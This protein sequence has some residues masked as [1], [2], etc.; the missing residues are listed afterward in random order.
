MIH[1]VSG[2]SPAAVWDLLRRGRPVVVTDEVGRWP[3]ARRWTFEFMREQHGSIVV[4]AEVGP[5]GVERETFAMRLGDYVDRLLDPAET[6]L[7]LRHWEF[8]RD[9]P[10]LDADQRLPS[11]LQDRPRLP[12]R[13][14]PR[15]NWI[16]M[17]PRGSRTHLHVDALGTHSWLAQLRGRKRWLLFSPRQ[18]S[19]LYPRP[20][21]WGGLGVTFEVDPP[22]GVDLARYPRY[23]GAQ[24]WVVETG[25]GDL[26][27][28]PAGWPHCVEN[29]EPTMALTGNFVGPGCDVLAL[30]REGLGHELEAVYRSAARRVSAM[31][32]SS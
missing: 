3:A 8:W 11:Y 23:R 19:R 30:L 4:T 26:M 12:R 14:W 6:R 29:L 31:S 5:G 7:H 1:R 24:P 15:M 22:A 13:A 2:V 25:P 32:S 18:T 27:I 9:A 20:Y 21:R 28:V 10:L 16:F 17:G